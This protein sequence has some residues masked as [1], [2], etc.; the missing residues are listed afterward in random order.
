MVQVLLRDQLVD[1]VNNV[2][3]CMYIQQAHVKI[4]QEALVRGLELESILWSTR[5]VSSTSDIW[6]PYRAG[7]AGT[8]EELPRP[9]LLLL[10]HP[11]LLLPF[12]GGVPGKLFWMGISR[13][14]SGLLSLRKISD[15]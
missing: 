13:A 1:A 2:Q 15:K 12:T 9:A 3:I 10:T 5:R 14:Q 8:Y 7:Q 4:L 6:I 11:A